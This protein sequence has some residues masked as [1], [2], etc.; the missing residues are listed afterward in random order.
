MA[1]SK[2]SWSLID[3]TMVVEILATQA[4]V[5]F[6]LAKI[7]PD[8]PSYNDV[9]KHTIANGIKQ[10]LADHLARPTDMTLT[11]VEMKTEL[12][13]S[14]DRLCSGHWN[15][16]GRGGGG[17]KKAELQ[18]KVSDQAKQLDDMGIKLDEAMA[19]IEK[20]TAKADK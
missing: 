19:L 17:I 1:K 14:W 6:D 7:F 20:L 3:S 16:E 11:P 2:L 12:L 15:V 10:K 8:F 18:A 9:Q 13:A 5:S 4:K